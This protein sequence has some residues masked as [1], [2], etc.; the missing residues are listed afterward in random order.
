MKQLFDAIRAGDLNGVAS[1]LDADSSLANAKNEQGVSA[2]AFAV[3]NRKP[4]IASLLEGRGALLDIFSAAMTGKTELVQEML[5]G[6]KSLTKLISADGWTALHLAAFFGQ[7][8]VASALLN[9]GAV[10]NARSTN[11]MQNMP[12]HAGVAGRNAE[13][14]KLL[15]DFGADVNARQHGGW[16]PLHAACQNGDA[17]IAQMLLEN[18]ADPAARAEN[19]QSCFD[20]ALTRG[21]Q[22]IVDLL[23]KHGASF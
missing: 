15:I 1:Q 2:Y 9:A 6:N 5:A 17:A 10:V 22:A 12:L 19:N 13:V 18:G 7:P 16:T 11:P 8:G 23:E 20:L 3:Y 21:H 4:E 14:I